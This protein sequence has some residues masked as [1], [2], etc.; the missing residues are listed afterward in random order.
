MGPIRGY[1]K[2]KKIDKRTE[3][4]GSGSG[5]AEKEG[6]VDWWDEFSKRINGMLFSFTVIRFLLPFLLFSF[7]FLVWM[8]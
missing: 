8:F 2:R 5:S 1:K 3:E 6:P 7:V 4:N